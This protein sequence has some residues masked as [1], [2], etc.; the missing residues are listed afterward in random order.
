MALALGPRFVTGP[1]TH[2][3]HVGN[4]QQDPPADLG[5]RL[6][7][8]VYGPSV[9]FAQADCHRVH[10]VLCLVAHAKPLGPR[11]R[12]K[13]RRVGQAGAG[14]PFGGIV[15]AG[16]HVVSQSAVYQNLRSGVI[17]VEAYRGSMTICEHRYWTA[18]GLPA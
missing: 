4:T 5:H 17:V 14:R 13:S 8:K 7:G 18:L 3:G 15:I 11:L 16:Q 9:A 6:H 1:G 2:D 12:R 10:Q